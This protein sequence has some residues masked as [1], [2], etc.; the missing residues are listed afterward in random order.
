MGLSVEQR[1]SEAYDVLVSETYYSK[2]TDKQLD[3]LIFTLRTE[4]MERAIASGEYN[5]CESCL[6][7]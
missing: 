6:E 2:L 7:D 4:Q 5:P 1:A 3:S